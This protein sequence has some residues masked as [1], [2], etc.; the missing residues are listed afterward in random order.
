M[1]SRCCS[2]STFIMLLTGIWTTQFKHQETTGHSKNDKLMKLWNS[3]T[4][5]HK[6]SQ[7]DLNIYQDSTRKTRK[8]KGSVHIAAITQP[9]RN[10]IQPSSNAETIMKPI[11]IMMEHYKTKQI[12]TTKMQMKCNNKYSLQNSILNR[13]FLIHHLKSTAQT[14]RNSG[15]LQHANY[16]RTKSNLQHNY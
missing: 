12:R 3:T 1:D 7:C 4:S 2:N 15:E 9:T 10:E 8:R 13:G 5:S 16:A 14:Q 6:R 11:T